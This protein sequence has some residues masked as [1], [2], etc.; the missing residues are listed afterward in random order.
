MKRTETQNVYSLH[1]KN[2]LI[3]RQFYIKIGTIHVVV[4]FSKCVLL[5]ATHKCGTA[6]DGGW[7]ASG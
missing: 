6:K 3:W 2:L 5:S 7:G 1:E 4:K